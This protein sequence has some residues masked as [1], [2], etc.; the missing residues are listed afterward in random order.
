MYACSEN[1]AINTDTNSNV[2]AK[3]YRLEKKD[4]LTS[5]ESN[6]PNDDDDD[7]LLLMNKRYRLDKRYRFDKKQLNMNDI[8]DRKSVV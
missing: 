1:S 3:R 7:H 8:K 4:I 2:L 5:S 6:E